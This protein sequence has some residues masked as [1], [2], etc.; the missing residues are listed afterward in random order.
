[1]HLAVAVN[2]EGSGLLTREGPMAEPLCGRAQQDHV[3]ALPDQL[4]CRTS[5]VNEYLLG[6]QILKETLGP[7]FRHGC[8]Q[9]TSDDERRGFDLTREC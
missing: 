2:R 5:H 8:V 7:Y 1:M 4:V 3:L 9:V 6:F